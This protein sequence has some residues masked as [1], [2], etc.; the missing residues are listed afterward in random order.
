MP[1]W[2]KYVITATL[3]VIVSEVVRRTEKLG[4]FFG[5]LPWISIL[6]MVWLFWEKQSGDKIGSYASYTFYYVV[7]T[8]PMFLLLAWLLQKGWGFPAALGAGVALTVILF[9]F[10]G[11][12]LRRWGISLF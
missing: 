2:L 11:L 5:A 3:V 9:Y 8:L 4:A 12:V 7:P 10:W 6:V 1:L